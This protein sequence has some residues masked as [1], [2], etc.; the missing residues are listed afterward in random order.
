MEGDGVGGSDCVTA[1]G[2]FVLLLFDSSAGDTGY[3]G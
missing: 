3:I 2:S 1:G